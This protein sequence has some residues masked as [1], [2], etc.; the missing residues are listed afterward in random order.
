MADEYSTS[1]SFGNG[2]LDIGYWTI[3]FNIKKKGPAG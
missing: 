1:N 2:A 3:E